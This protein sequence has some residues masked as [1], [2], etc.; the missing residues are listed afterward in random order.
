MIH[1]YIY[2]YYSGIF[3]N[4]NLWFCSLYFYGPVEWNW[5]ERPKIKVAPQPPWHDLC[6]LRNQQFGSQLVCPPKHW[7][8]MHTIGLWMINVLRWEPFLFF[9]SSQKMAGMFHADFGCHR[10]FYQRKCIVGYHFMIHGKNASLVVLYKDKRLLYPCPTPFCAWCQDI[11]F[12]QLAAHVQPLPDGP[13][14]IKYGVIFRWMKR[15]KACLRVLQRVLET[16]KVLCGH[17]ATRQGLQ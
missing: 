5:E 15:W 16:E 8:V 17:A 9:R 6:S 1:I 13:V 11:A 12:Q 7:S 4:Q 10:A 3:G 14:Q 2:I